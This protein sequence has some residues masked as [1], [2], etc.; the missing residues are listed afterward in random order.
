MGLGR[1]RDGLAPTPPMGWNPWNRFQGKID[2][3]L[4]IESAEALV[5]SGLRDSGYRYV[6]TDDCWESPSRAPDGALVADP[7]RFP[8]GMRALADRVQALGLKLGIYT[9]AGTRTCQELPGSLGYEFRDAR[10]F[11]EWGADYVKVDWCN[12]NG[13]GPRAVYAKWALAI[14][15]ARRPMVLSICEW[16][17][18]HPWEWAGGIGHLWRT[19]WDIQ[20]TWESLLAIVERQAR[21]H[22]YAGPDHWNDPDMLEVG[23]GGMTDTEYR[24]QFSLWAVLAAPL[25]AGN[26]VREMRGEI[27]DLLT[28]PE[29]IAIDQDALGRQGRRVRA[30]DAAEVWVRELERGARAVALFN[31]GDAAREI[32]AGW[33]ELGWSDD[34]RAV[35]RDLWERREVGTFT[36]AFGAMVPPHAATLVRLERLSDR[37]RVDAGFPHVTAAAT[38]RTAAIGRSA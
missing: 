1:L 31:R 8:H 25:M 14:H 12:T 35:V 9:D 22:P 23:N 6:V 20:D 5:E 36:E 24:A 28:A 2:E 33:M 19:S 15:A 30:A 21:L 29:V 34:V 18:S 17:R 32:V 26:D 27:R 13:L 38:T 7:D 3:R 11:A 4:L 16:G 37:P 10:S